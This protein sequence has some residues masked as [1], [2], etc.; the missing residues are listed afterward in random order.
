MFIET[1]NT[2]IQ[3][4]E[5]KKEVLLTF[6]K[7]VDVEAYPCGRRR[8][9]LID[10][11]KNSDEV[12]SDTE[13]IQFPFDPEARLNTEANNRKH[14]GLNGYTQTYL[15]SDWLNSDNTAENLVVALNGYLFKIK[16]ATSNNSA[17]TFGTGIAA[18]LNDTDAERIYA[19]ILIEDIK[20]FSSGFREYFTGVLRDQT[21]SKE[22]YFDNTPSEALDLL[23]SGGAVE[24]KNA[25]NYYFSG[26][27][28]STAPLTSLVNDD[29]VEKTRSTEANTISYANISETAN[30]TLVSLCIL[31]KVDGK[32]K[33]HE[34]ARLPFI[35]HGK[36]ANSI[37]VGDTLVERT[38]TNPGDLTVEGNIEVGKLDAE[39][40]LMEGTG[41]ITAEG[42]LKVKG[43]AEIIGETTL[44]GAV[45]AKATAIFEDSTEIK[46]NLTVGT[47]GDSTTGTVI[48]KTLVEAPTIEAI[49]I[50]SEGNQI[51]QITADNVTVNKN[52]GTWNASIGNDLTVTNLTKTKNFEATDTF[53]VLAYNEDGTQKKDQSD[54]PIKVTIEDGTIT[55][56]NI[57]DTSGNEITNLDVTKAKFNNMHT[58]KITVAGTSLDG[59]D[60]G[61]FAY[62]MQHIIKKDT[63]MANNY[64]RP[65]PYIDFVEQDDGTWQLQVSRVTAIQNGAQAPEASLP[66]EPDLQLEPAVLSLR[67][68]TDE[69]A[70]VTLQIEDPSGQ[71]TGYDLKIQNSGEIIS[72][73]SHSGES[74]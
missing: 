23:K 40:K 8:S 14:S 30:Q 31:E 69:T 24:E 42:N 63:N 72:N 18:A 32:W 71:A 50:D 53:S 27:S 20:L 3:V 13:R 64:N 45:T 29:N 34:P 43:N 33:V 22:G 56:K 17:N 37:V 15:I 26:L 59:S 21:T 55:A 74:K 35:E 73:I 7:S 60:H 16:L 67:S 28:F 68:N 19:N 11:D 46:K 39:G 38:D 57:K 41:D 52:F 47:D 36:T 10:F 1:H 62:N 44:T 61:L 54:E 70:A 66:V 12:I 58:Q 4:G 49:A 25:N 2:Y 9:A 51:G 65:V 5:T 6:L 48:A